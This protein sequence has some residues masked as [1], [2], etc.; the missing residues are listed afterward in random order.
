M[1]LLHRLHPLD[2]RYRIRTQSHRHLPFKLF[3]IGCE[4]QSAL[5]RRRL[6]DEIWACCLNFEL[7]TLNVNL[8]E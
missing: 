7:T 6:V 3:L 8:C 2:P 5:R 1:S 4:L